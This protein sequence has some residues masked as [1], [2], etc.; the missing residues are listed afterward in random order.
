MRMRLVPTRMHAH[1][2]VAAAG[3]AAGLIGLSLAAYVIVF[4]AIAYGSVRFY[5]PG[6]HALVLCYAA[7]CYAAC[8]ASWRL[9]P[10]S[11]TRQ[12]WRPV[13]ASYAIAAVA[14]SAQFIAMRLQH[15][16]D[17]RGWVVAA[18]AL[19]VVLLLHSTIALVWFTRRYVALRQVAAVAQASAERAAAESELRALQHQVDPH[20][21]FNNLS[22][23]GGLVRRDPAQA[24][25]FVQQ[26]TALYRYLVRHGRAE[27]VELD[28]E[29]AFARSYV[30]LLEVRFGRAFRVAIALPTGTGW[31]AIPGL[32]QELL[33]NVVKHNHGSEDEPVE[34]E[35]KLDGERL[36]AIN[37]LR[38]RRYAEPRSGHGLATLSERY[39]LQAGEPLAWQASG[40]RF[41]VTVPLIAS[42]R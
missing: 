24:E 33:H 37:S 13:A 15:G 4:I 5:S 41:I 16:S 28:E 17:V 11:Q 10:A 18:N 9:W 2:L 21:L 40:G 35:L 36:L 26:L 7:A 22:I 12:L 39:R 1:R 19:L 27:W 38:P 42:A 30:H 6:E 29:I 20:F 3:I 8:W 23:L 25:R 14:T 32:L 31:F 34:V